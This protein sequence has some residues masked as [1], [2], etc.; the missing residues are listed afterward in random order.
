MPINRSPAA[1]A[2][3]ATL[4]GSMRLPGPPWHHSTGRSPARPWSRKP[5]ARPSGRSNRSSV[6]T[7]TVGEPC[8]RSCRNAGTNAHNGSARE[9]QGGEL[10][11]LGDEAAGAVPHV[12]HLVGEAVGDHLGAEAQ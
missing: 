2:A 1:V 3:A 7:A 8:A 12:E 5:T 4:A 11:R 6:T 9:A 10:G